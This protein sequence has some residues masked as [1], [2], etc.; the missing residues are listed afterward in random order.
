MNEVVSPGSADEAL[1]MLQSAMGTW[2][3][4]MPRRWR[5]RSRRGLDPGPEPRRH[6][7]R[8]EQEQNK[9]PAQPRT[10]RPPGV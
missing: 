5:P 10:P 6:H 1:E 3:R 9:N 7:H 2:R 8:V 4:P